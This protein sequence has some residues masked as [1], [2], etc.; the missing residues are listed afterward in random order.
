MESINRWNKAQY[1]GEYQSNIGKYVYALHAFTM[2][3]PERYILQKEGWLVNF[4]D[5]FITC[6]KKRQMQRNS[7]KT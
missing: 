2:V 6:S 7:T 3:L 4:A 5:D 1:R